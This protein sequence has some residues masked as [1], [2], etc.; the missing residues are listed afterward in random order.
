MAADARLV[1]VE[2]DG[3]HLLPVRRLDRVRHLHRARV[4]CDD[5]VVQAHAQRVRVVRIPTAAAEAGRGG[6]HVEVI[7]VLERVGARGRLGGRR[8]RRAVRQRV[9]HQ[10]VPH[11]RANL[12]GQHR[13][14][15]HANVLPQRHR[16]T[17]LQQLGHRHGGRRLSGRGALR[18]HR[19]LVEAVHPPERGAHLAVVDLPR[20]RV[21]GADELGVLGRGARRDP[22]Y[23]MLVL[24]R[25][26]AHH[27]ICVLI[28]VEDV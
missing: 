14:P 2:V 8:R 11:E 27:L 20:F 23:L 9:Q 5:R 19:R 7:T 25:A 24:E 26:L 10:P 6:G 18:R 3:L 16:V 22:P 21:G 13:V 17:Q 1:R 12:L 15:D 4:D 28:E